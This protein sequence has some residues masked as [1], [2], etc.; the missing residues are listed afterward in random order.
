MLAD[1]V[2]ANRATVT[3]AAAAAATAPRVLR[4]V[5]IS[6]APNRS[7]VLLLLRRYCCAPCAL[8]QASLLDA[9]I[10]ETD[11]VAAVHIH[12]LMKLLKAHYSAFLTTYTFPLVSVTV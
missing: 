2:H 12:K 7:A 9:S 5:R 10:S 3:A 4:Y 6:A 11:H 1:T 8:T